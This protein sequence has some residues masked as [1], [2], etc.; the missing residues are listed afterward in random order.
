MRKQHHGDR[1]RM[2]ELLGLSVSV[3]ELSRQRPLCP[4]N[5]VAGG[6]VHEEA[7]EMVYSR[8]T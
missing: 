7:A 4:L 8:Q 6:H 2:Q 3:D 5:R 1:P